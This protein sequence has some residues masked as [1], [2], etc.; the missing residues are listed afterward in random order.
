MKPHDSD[1]DLNHLAKIAH[2]LSGLAEAQVLR[3]SSQK[4]FRDE[5]ISKRW[6]YLEREHIPQAEERGPSQKA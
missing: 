4:E 5:V 1:W 2:F 3:V 6:I